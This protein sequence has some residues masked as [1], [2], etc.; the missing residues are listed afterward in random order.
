MEFAGIVLERRRNKITFFIL[1]DPDC[2]IDK[3]VNAFL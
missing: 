2:S 1:E 3:A